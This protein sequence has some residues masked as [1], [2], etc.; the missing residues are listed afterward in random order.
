M[1]RLALL[2]GQQMAGPGNNVGF[3]LNGGSETI[4]PTS[5]FFL[6]FLFFPWVQGML[7]NLSTL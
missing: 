7:V 5:N 3:L 6:V 2:V 1:L 4:P